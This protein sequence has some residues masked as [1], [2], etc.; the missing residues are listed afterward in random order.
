MKKVV[1]RILKG[2]AA[3]IV[4]MIVW[5]TTPLDGLTL[6]LE[7]PH[8][9]SIS[10]FNGGHQTAFVFFTGTQSDGIAHSAP[11]RDLWAQHAD[12]VVVE[13]NRIRFDGRQT[14]YDT[15][16]KLREWGY[17]RVILDGASLGGL[18]A[19]DVIDFDRALGNH[20]KFVVM[21]QDVPMDEDD[22]YQHDQA[23]TLSTIWWPGR[24]TDVIGTS[25]FW[26]FGFHPPARNQLGTGVNDQQLA[27]HYHASK[28][29]PLSGWK[30]EIRYIVTHR[31]FI[32]NQYVGI[33]L[34]YMV[35]E[36]DSVVKPN[37]RRWKEVFGGGTVITVPQS[38]HIGF[39][40][41]PDRWKTAFEAAFR[42]LPPGW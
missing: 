21:M 2:L 12:D 9:T 42:S 29:Y 33:P 11:L 15:Y 25:A 23:R 28:T 16:L 7:S 40:E 20:M 5:V 34:I 37:A 39:V 4:L 1:G 22:L 36:K 10:R 17:Q 6:K 41:F 38:T 32:R 27:A 8:P 35:A 13:Y 30:G 18:L 3:L 31:G 26:H 24:L 19:T 14:A